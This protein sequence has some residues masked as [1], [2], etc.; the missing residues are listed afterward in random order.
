MNVVITGGLGVL[1]ERCAQAYLR[2][3]AKVVI[4][5]LQAEKDLDTAFND[6]GGRL[7]YVQCDIRKYDDCKNLVMQSELF[8]KEPIEVY[9]ANAGVPFAGDFLDASQEQIQNVIHVNVLGSMYCAQTA[10][11]SL[12]KNKQSHLI[13]TCSLQSTLARSQRSIYTTSKHALAGLVK[14]LSLEFARQGLHVNGIA[15]AAIETP[16]LFSAFEGAKI[17]NADGLKIAAESLPLGRIP[18]AEEFA[19]TALFLTSKAAAS[20]TGQLINLDAGA[21]AG[22]FPRQAI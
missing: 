20:I 16:F 10:I 13:F 9:I 17:T 8:F 2:I 12:I 3:G 19:E 5:D 14:S 11:P 22:I 15:P 7:K 18:N 21:S 1:G 4:A 6:E